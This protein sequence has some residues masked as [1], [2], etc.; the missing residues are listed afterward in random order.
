[1]NKVFL[2]GAELT[3]AQVLQIARYGA[4]VEITPTARQRLAD[5]RQLVFDLVDA[6]YPI[7]GFNVGVGQNKDKKVFKQFFGEYNCN[8]IRS[9][10]IGVPPYAS[11]E[12]VRAT[13]V[14]RLN[15][16]LTGCCGVSP[17]IPEMYM[18]MLNH[19][20]HPLIPEKGSVGQ[21]DIGLISHIGLA[22]IGEGN[23][24][25]N[26]REMP[27]TEAFA[28]VGL[29]P[30]TLGP[31]DGLAI[32]SSNALSAGACALLLEDIEELL[33]LSE[34]I[35]AMSLE[36]LN[37]NTAPLD[38][39]NH[40]LRRFA[41]Q[42]ESA[43][44]ISRYLQGSYIYE[45]DSKK[46]VHDPLS[47]RSTPQITGAA[48]EMLAYTK[49]RLEIQLNTT[50]DNPCL[51]LEDRQI[52]PSANFDPLN[53]VLG[54]EG[55]AIALSHVS[56]TACMRLIKLVTPN[57][58]NLP[59]F[60]AP[61]VDVLC[62]ATLQKTFTSLDAEI[63][64]LC[65]PCSMDTFSLAGDMEDTS[66]NATYAVQNLRRIYRNLHIIFAIE[67]IHATQAMEYRKK[68]SFG[69]YTGKA[70]QIVRKV[71]PFYKTDRNITQDIQTVCE[72]LQSGEL[73]ALI[74][75]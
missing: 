52:S 47:Y 67:L 68:L 66:T 60:L 8:L 58:T 5:A 44:R 21:A 18:A 24:R 56:K 15:T 1:M 72:L 35:Y 64:H 28:K 19:G 73:T 53:W 65:N 29:K 48:R 4:P 11:D 36:G 55:L 14:A 54:V 10:C 62:F 61:E 27:A 70:F 9:H 30:L 57:Y 40:A 7:Y 42:R 6:D 59:R 51:L 26:G 45:V 33:D 3:T 20:I 75:E 43:R 32:V 25:M 16:M 50:D 2:S 12:D 69:Q 39:R 49:E 63:R 34:L 46:A 74:R 13:M 41:G 22:I 17:E 38:D 37:G 31:K 71:L 23:V